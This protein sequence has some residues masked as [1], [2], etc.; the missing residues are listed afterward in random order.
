MAAKDL[1]KAEEQ[2]LLEFFKLTNKFSTSNMICFDFEGKI[3]KYESPED[4]LEAFYPVRLAYYQKRKDHLANEIQAGLDKLTNQAR[5]IQLI[6]DKQLTVANRKKVDIVQDLR[7]HN[8]K[9]FPKATRAKAAGK[10]SDAQDDEEEDDDD[11]DEDVGNTSQGKGKVEDVNSDYDYLLGMAIWSLTKE[12]IAKLKMQAEEK[13]QELLAL[14]ARSP[15]SMW[16]ADLDDFLAMWNVSCNEWYERSSKDAS[17][18]K[19]KRKQTVLQTRKSIGGTRKGS[20]DDD[21]FKVPAKRKAP[22]QS[23]RPKP[24]KAVK[25]EDDLQMNQA[26]NPKP[27]PA[28]P[29]RKA[30]EKKPNK[31]DLDDDDDNISMLEKPAPKKATKPLAIPSDSEDEVTSL[32]SKAKGKAKEAPKL[33]SDSDDDFLS[34]PP[35]TMAAKGKGK[36]PAVMKRKSP[37]LVDE[38]SDDLGNKPAAK[39]MKVTDFFEK[40]VPKAKEAAAAPTAR[41][42]SKNMKPASPPKPKPKPQ[43]KAKAR[44]LSESDDDDDKFDYDNL[45]LPKKSAPRAARTT[46][47]APKKYIELTDDDDEEEGGGDEDVSMFV[48]E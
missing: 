23:T 24:K 45:P 14:L 5:F 47:A 41:K 29:K 32:P 13:E 12:K 48:D 18:R 6:V 40:T 35:T 1:Q 38:E 37:T 44:A 8:F 43:A 17:G 11:E 20:D 27:R 33:V 36:A 16:N 2:G 15:K 28:A 22:V 3:H 30:A 31:I 26:P 10:T 19:V 7:K 34:Y 39:K 46:A 21:D 25:D 42:I 4:I 9:P